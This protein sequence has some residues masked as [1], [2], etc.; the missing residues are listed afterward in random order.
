MAKFVT[1]YGR[2]NEA[3][4]TYSFTSD[5]ADDPSYQKI[6]WHDVEGIYR[7]NLSNQI[8]KETRYPNGK[9]KSFT[10]ETK[11]DA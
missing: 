6:Y 10:V 4:K 7:N 1:L 8:V 2:L 9:F 11:V 5:P 3:E